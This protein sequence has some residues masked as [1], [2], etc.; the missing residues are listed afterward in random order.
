M[1]SVRAKEILQIKTASG[2]ALPSDEIL[3]EIFLEAM[4]YVANKCVPSELIRGEQGGRVYRHL[5]DGFYITY[6]DKPNF[7][8]ENEHIMIDESL[9]YAVINYVAFI[10]NKDEFYRSLALENISEYIANDGRGNLYE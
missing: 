9:T 6:P 10:I 5:E 8:N 3:S 2:R 7:A 4:L 1:T